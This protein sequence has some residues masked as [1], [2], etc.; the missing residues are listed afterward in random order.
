MDFEP[1]EIDRK[2]L[3][4]DDGSLRSWVD[5]KFGQGRVQAAMLRC[6]WTIYGSVKLKTNYF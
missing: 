5:I 3:V 4:E 6:Y 2:F 1:E